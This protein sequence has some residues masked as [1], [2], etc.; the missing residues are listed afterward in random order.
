MKKG[1]LN[2]VCKTKTATNNDKKPGCG[3]GN[4]LS[5]SNDGNKAKPPMS[6]LVNTKPSG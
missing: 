5:Y 1:E 3:W 4:R 6:Q 2:K